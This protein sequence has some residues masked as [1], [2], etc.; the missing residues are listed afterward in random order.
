MAHPLAALWEEQQSDFLEVSGDSITINYKPVR[1]G[2]DPTFDNFFQESTD[3]SDPSGFENITETTATPEV[4][5]GKMHLD[6]YGLA[7]SSDES[8]QQ[9][10]IGRFAES[11]A[12]FT[13]LLS[14]VQTST[15]TDQIKTKFHDAL[16]VIPEK[17][18][19]R[20]DVIAIKSRGMAAAFVVDVFLKKTNK[21][22]L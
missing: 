6:L 2:T 16:Y 5:T 10:G 19:I 13:C 18:G 17:D 22:A 21:E 9:L 1:T 4:V 15:G 12:L 8:D 11:D 20:Y 3:P 14:D 7:I